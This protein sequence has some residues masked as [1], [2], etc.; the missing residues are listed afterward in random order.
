MGFEKFWLQ[1]D[2]ELNVDD[3][4]EDLAWFQIVEMWTCIYTGM[5][6]QGEGGGIANLFEL[7]NAKEEK[8]LKS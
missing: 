4:M 8:E 3:W 6:M 7:F 5:Q 1:I 2:E